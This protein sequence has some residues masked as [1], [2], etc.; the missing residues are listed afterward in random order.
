MNETNRLYEV[1]I[2]AFLVYLILS[3]VYKR[4]TVRNAEEALKRSDGLVL[5]NLKNIMGILLFGVLFYVLLPDFRFLLW[6]FQ[7]PSTYIL[8]LAVLVIMASGILAYRSAR[9]KLN[10]MDYVAYHSHYKVFLYA[11]I[12]ILFLISYE[13]FFRGVLFFSLLEIMSLWEAILITTVLYVV[14]HGFDSRNEIIGAIPFGMVL[15]L[16]SYV[17]QSVIIACL[18]HLSLSLIYECYMF[19]RLTYKKQLS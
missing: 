13:F 3:Y 17:T 9:N 5:I 15:C 19:H 4:I 10:D 12:R 1:M 14:I 7:I 8:G 18:I 11:P 16:F 6:S 2:T